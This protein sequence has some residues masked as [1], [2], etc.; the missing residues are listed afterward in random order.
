MP[1]AARRKG[2]WIEER[3]D[4][5]VYQTRTRLELKLLGI[6][7]QTEHEWSAELGPEDFAQLK[8]FLSRVWK[9]PLTASQRIFL[10]TPAPVSLIQCK[11]VG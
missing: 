1:S 8:E 6:R 9:S 4:L 11:P 7:R 3:R 2:K 5:L 10:G